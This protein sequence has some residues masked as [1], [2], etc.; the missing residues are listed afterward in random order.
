M[1]KGDSGRQLKVLYASQTKTSP[2][3]FTLVASRADKLYF[4]DSRRIENV[5][6]KA[7][8]FAGTPILF[9][10]SARKRKKAG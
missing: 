10:V 2:P 9:H 1:P 8:D 7:A 3:T 4:S 5:F 6:R